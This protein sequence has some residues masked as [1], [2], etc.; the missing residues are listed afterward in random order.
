MDECRVGALDRTYEAGA[1]DRVEADVEARRQAL[2][3]HAGERRL[4]RVHLE[5]AEPFADAHHRR[6][7]VG[8]ADG[9][10]I[11]LGRTEQALDAHRK[12]SAL[13]PQSVALLY[14]LTED[15]EARGETKV[16]AEV[17]PVEVEA[18]KKG[19]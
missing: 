6:G 7:A 19:R 12:G 10:A 11:A 18:K 9:D 15:Y 4:F 14:Q 5:R 17:R 16:A 2:A 8:G 3:D 13:Y 1:E